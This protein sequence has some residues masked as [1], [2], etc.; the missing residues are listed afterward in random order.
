M[1]TFIPPKPLNP[2]F[3]T[4]K[5]PA[6]SASTPGQSQNNAATPAPGII[7]PASGVKFGFKGMENH[8]VKASDAAAHAASDDRISAQGQLIEQEMFGVVTDIRIYNGGWGVGKI[9]TPDGKTLTIKGDSLSDL[10]LGQRYRLRGI[11]LHHPKYGEQ[12]DVKSAAPDMQD[13]DALVRHVQNNYS[14]VGQQT[15][16]QLVRHHRDVGT[17]DALRDALIYA[18]ST[19]DF[20]AFTT[21]RVQLINTEDS[22]QRRVRDS[23]TMRFSGMG[24]GQTLATDLA[25]YLLDKARTVA[26]ERAANEPDA[27]A[28]DE[29]RLANTILD[30]NPYLPMQRVERYGFR[31]ADTIAHTLKIGK[32]DSRRLTAIVGHSLNEGCIGA[33][34][35]WLSRQELN[36]WVRRADPS[37]TPEHAIQIASES[38]FNIYVETTPS[39][40]E[41]IYPRKLYFE[42]KKLARNLAMRVTQPIE[43]LFQG[44]LD[45][46][47]AAIDDAMIQI[48]Y[49]KGRE[50][51]TLDPSQRAA[52]IGV[53]TSPCSLHTITGGPGCGKTTIV[54]VIMHVL[55]NQDAPPGRVV[56]CAPTGKAAKVL[57]ARVNEW[58][59]S[60]TIHRTLGFR[61][62]FVHNSENPLDAD[63]VT[64]DEQSMMG[65]SLSAA[66]FDAI[67]ARAHT[68]LL[69][70]PGQLESIDP[71]AV[72][73][74]ILRV[75][76]FDHHRLTTTHRNDGDLLSVIKEVG[77]GRCDAKSRVGVEFVGNLPQID[78]RSLSAL[79]REVLE[80]AKK[81]G[82]LEKVGVICP[83]RKGNPSTPDWNVTYLNHALKE[84]LNPNTEKV[85]GTT[86]NLNDRVIITSNM[87]VLEHNERPPI[88][89]LKA[90]GH[91]GDQSQDKM[92]MDAFF[93]SLN[94]SPAPKGD[95]PFD[96]D[97]AS[98]RDDDDA[99]AGLEET[100]VVNGD[101]GYIV[102]AHYA[103]INHAG[104]KVNGVDYLVL[105]LDDGRYVRFPGD[106]LESLAPA[107]A[108][109]T[110]AAQGSEYQKVFAFVTDGN[111][112]FMTRS[113]MFTQFSR[114]QKELKVYGE[115][116]VLQKVAKRTGVE[117]NCGLFDAVTERIEKHRRRHQEQLP[118]QVVPSAH[119]R[120]RVA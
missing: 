76:T 85:R 72:L 55:H 70:D 10:T 78:A 84:A 31:I 43:P 91:D 38:G 39:G 29:V 80:S 114:A 28:I 8:V 22:V 115:P 92:D 110:H 40:Q 14:G 79:T 103:Q 24:L 50:P 25:R 96:F 37:I 4:A 26:A 99:A 51:D 82:G 54:E 62:E 102:E 47:Q 7:P 36:E 30:E 81:Y 105:A 86:F 42:Q 71:G 17:L 90:H 20:S 60:N 98:D 32:N 101:T 69:G 68:I 41:R 104:T 15:A 52:I 27:P 88:Q 67:P 49:A 57:N 3:S 74:S 59:E 118:E 77:E 106:S 61:G 95:S 75:D 5:K 6:A 119:E 100:Y 46:L 33:G 117:R 58:G 109:T 1:V 112:R 23:L 66:F 13:I 63:I 48:A 12:F 21:R 93:A 64:G 116:D 94:T 18:P 120:Q 35:V 83:K 65:T 9:I 113:M 56:F 97:T 16:L 111:E 53:L 44:G 108:I 11:S 19:V 45:A 89:G 2:A 107:Y 73:K 34:H 87:P